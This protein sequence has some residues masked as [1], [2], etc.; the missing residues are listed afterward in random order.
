M[1]S[2]VIERLAEVFDELIL[3]TQDVF[4]STEGY[5]AL[6]ALIPDAALVHTLRSKWVA[7]PSRPSTDK[8]QDLRQLVKNHKQKVRRGL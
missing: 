1:N 7:D 8:W 6:L 3:E 5:E 2:A 4:A